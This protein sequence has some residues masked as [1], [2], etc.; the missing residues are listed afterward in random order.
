MQQVTP[1]SNRPFY[2]KVQQHASKVCITSVGPPGLD[3]QCTQPAMGG[4][5]PICLPTSS[6]IG[7]S[8][9]EV[10]RLPMQENNSDYS[11]VA[12]HAL[13]LGSSGHVQSNST[14]P[15]QPA[16]SAHSA[17]HPNLNMHAW[18]SNQGAGLLR[19]SIS[20]NW[21]PSERINQISLWGKVDHFYK[22][23]ASVISWTSG[24]LHKISNWLP[25]VPVSG[26]D[27]YTPVPLMDTGQPLP[28][29]WGIRLSM[30]AKMKISLITWIVS[31]ETDPKDGG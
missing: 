19:G 23:G 13:V 1:T 25:Y 7:Q 30:S 20:M 10:A 17:I 11:G 31:T 4:S 26:Q 22:S 12:K 18:L 16:Q 21:G 2:S 8:G 3:S 29:N 27:V 6:H 28:I 15:G 5:G 9:G 24:Y 14:V